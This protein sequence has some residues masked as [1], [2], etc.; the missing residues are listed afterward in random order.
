M[1]GQKTQETGSSYTSIGSK[2][3]QEED[4]EVMSDQPQKRL[5]VSTPESPRV[6]IDSTTASCSHILDFRRGRIDYDSVGVLRTKPG[7]VDSE[8]TL[9]MS[10]SDKIARWNVLGLT[11]ALLAPFLKEPIYLTSVITK[12]LFDARALSR[13]LVD[14]VRACDCLEVVGDGRAKRW[15]PHTINILESQEPFEFSKETVMKVAEREGSSLPPVASASSKYLFLSFHSGA[16][17]MSRSP[18]CAS[19][20]LSM[21]S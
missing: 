2:R 3:T 19:S 7:R 20:R 10:C 11:S 18:V 21:N 14:R 16:V 12:E 6:E 9:S 4:E 17:F 13:A 8:P 15:F 1:K 5:C